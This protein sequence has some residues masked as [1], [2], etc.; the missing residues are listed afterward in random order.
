ML[1]MIFYT[2]PLYVF[3]AETEE[4]SERTEE[5]A[6]ADAE[7]ASQEDGGISLVRGVAEVT[8]R[9]EE[10]VKHFLLEDGSYRLIAYDSPVHYKDADGVWQDI[11]NTLSLG[12][13]EWSSADARIKFAKKITG[14]E[15]LFTLHDG[16]RKLAVSLEGALKKTEGVVYNGSEES[17]AET[18]LQKMMT[19]A[20]LYSRIVYADILQDVDLEYVLNGRNIKENLIVKQRGEGYSYTFTLALNGMQASL[21]EDGSVQL[22]D[23]DE[24]LYVMPTPYVYDADGEIALQEQAYFTLTDGGN[25]KYTLT[26]TVDDAWMNDEARAYPVTVDPAIYVQDG[27]GEIDTY[28]QSES[29]DT[30]NASSN[31]LE[32]GKIASTS[33]RYSYWRRSTLPE[34]PSNSYIVSARLDMYPEGWS[35][36]DQSIWQQIIT[37][38]RVTSY[39]SEGITWNTAPSYDSNEASYQII[40]EL[41]FGKY[42]SFDITSLVHSWY[43]D[44]DIENYGVR[45]G[46]LYSELACVRFSSTTS[47]H[48]PRFMID[49]RDMKG[50]EDYWSYQSQDVGYAGQGAVNLANGNLV[51]SIGTLTSTDALLPVTPTL[52]YNSMLGGVDYQYPYVDTSYVTSYS[53][54]GFK[55]NL[56]ETIIRKARYLQNGSTQYYYVWADGD[57]TEHS[58]LP[59]KDADGNLIANEYRDEDGLGLTLNT[60][61]MTITDKSHTVRKF[62]KITGKVVEGLIGRWYLSSITDQSGNKVSFTFDASYRPTAILLYP[63]G[64]T[65]GIEQLRIAYSGD[66]PYV[67]WNP[68]SGHAVVLR[69]SFVPQGEIVTTNCSYLREI[70]YAHVNT[71]MTATA[72]TWQSFWTNE[73]SVSGITVDARASY[74][75]NG[76]GRLTKAKD[77]KTGYEVV[78]TYDSTFHV[79]QITENGYV[80][81]SATATVG[82]TVKFTYGVGYT[83]VQSSGSDDVIDTSDDLITHTSF[84]YAGRPVSSFV[85]NRTRTTI[86]GASSGEYTDNEMAANS[87]KSVAQTSSLSVNHLYNGSFEEG[88]TEWSLNGSVSRVQANPHSGSS[89]LK[90]PISSGS[91]AYITQY[92][93]LDDGAYTLTFYIKGVAAKN[94]NVEVSISNYWNFPNAYEGSVYDLTYE[95]SE[96]YTKYSLQFNASCSYANGETREKLMIRIG[97]TGESGASGTIYIDDVT[98]TQGTGADSFSVVRYGSFTATRIDSSGNTV[99]VDSNAWTCN[100]VQGAIYDGSDANGGAALGISGEIAK[101][102]RYGQ[103]VSFV[104]HVTTSDGKNTYQISAMAK[105][106]K[107]TDY[108]GA[109]FGILVTVRYATKHANNTITYEEETPRLFSFSRHCTEWQHL[110]GVFPVDVPTSTNKTVEIRIECVYEGH[111]GDAYFDN[112]SLCLA[113]GENYVSYEYDDESGDVITKTTPADASQ[114]FYD[115][116]DHL[117]G[118][119]SYNTYTA[120]TYDAEH[121]LKEEYTYVYADHVTPPRG[122]FPEVGG[123]IPVSLGFKPQTRTLYQ[124]NTFGLVTAISVSPAVYTD[125]SG[126]AVHTTGTTSYTGYA[127]NTSSTSHIFGA[128]TSE[129]DSLGNTTQYI[130]DPSTGLLLATVAPDENAGYVYTYDA[131]GILTAVHPINYTASTDTYTKDTT[132]A[133]ASYTYDSQG[134]IGSIATPTTAYTFTYNAFGDV[135]GV[136]VGGNTLVTNSYKSKNG[137][138]TKITYA[139]GSYVQYSYNEKEQIYSIAYKSAGSSIKRVNYVYDANG[140]LIS[141]NDLVS[142]TWHRYE[143]DGKDRL[144]YVHTFREDGDALTEVYTYDAESRMT[145]N[146]M[147]LQANGIDID[148]SQS[149]TY[150]DYSNNV[151]YA[152]RF[153]TGNVA[154][155]AEL[156]RGVHYDAL[157]RVT[158]KTDA[159]ST[160]NSASSMPAVYDYTYADTSSRATGR[161]SLIESTIGTRGI[162]TYYTYDE[163]GNITCIRK[164]EAGYDQSIYYTYDKLGQLIREDNPIKNKTYVY[165]YDR[166]GNITSKKTYAYTLASSIT[167]SPTDTRTYT[168]GNSSFG[169]LLTKYNGMSLAYDANFNPTTYYNGTSY[170]MSWQYGRQLASVTKG[171]TTTSYTYNADGIRTSKTVGGVEHKYVLSG[172]QIVAEYYG[173]TT[174]IYLYDDSGAPIGL[175]T[176]QSSDVEGVYQYYY[177]EKNLQGDIL[178]IY[179][180]SGQKVVWYMYD[181]Y[182]NITTAIASGYGTLRD[183]NPFRYR[184]YYYDTETGFYYLNSRYYDPVTGRFINIDGSISG[185]GGNLLGNNLF[186]YCFNNPI[187]M[188][189]EQGEWP[190]WLTGALNV[191]GGALQVVAGATLGATLGWTGVG[192]VAAGFLAANGAA[193]VAQGACQVINDVTDTNTFREDNILRTSAVDLGQAIGGDIGASIAGGTYDIAVFAATAYTSLYGVSSFSHGKVVKNPGVPFKPGVRGFQSGVNPNTLKPTKDLAS[194]DPQRIINAVKYGGDQAISVSLSGQILDGHHRVADAIRN[195]RMIDIFV[196][197]FR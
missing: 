177:F 93:R 4:G 29:P 31:Y 192:A 189:D 15:A 89:S 118:V 149:Y 100:G 195:G 42:I 184:G 196:E 139:D 127:Y 113:T 120:Y 2:L 110:V 183:S 174:N 132:S 97:V 24:V 157:G 80:G 66:V 48:P 72:S 98:V 28:T 69:Y 129:T 135:T 165:T 68:T 131:S 90:F 111:V 171:G 5:S 65:T 41:S 143:Y 151:A 12:G 8:E 74:T 85:T 81:G 136:A 83:E 167:S 147:R 94:A 92:V 51:F 55:L 146:A 61:T 73:A 159:L 142:R 153:G 125:T 188:I 179:T 169:D 11:D 152:V 60:S 14:N 22:K 19:L 166:G 64:V 182:G 25:G 121:R 176:R 191:I 44:S 53:P 1:L 10:S 117:T 30:G 103:Y 144:L 164:L 181:A 187:N 108:E 172:S 109:N 122:S 175:A 116:D 9:R 49:Y 180:S 102:N 37:L 133:Y 23:G 63:S 32:V 194:L 112:I 107:Q 35:R 134:R 70:V 128:M 57:G 77:E 26:V 173:T 50:V 138:P 130:Y 161:V 76:G 59:A 79:M 141:V 7:V 54:C 36:Y 168:Y 185:V 124:Y 137:K 197:P 193:T 86:Y 119:L 95:T 67:I 190:K 126:T 105:G 178:G 71:G 150:N 96:E 33:T 87:L 163:N 114:Y 13:S 155:K 123:K 34:L 170:S 52:V 20:H 75:Y 88:T 101:V 160:V 154:P 21:T 140:R 17:I 91:S 27:T 47:N 104:P 43:Y 16:N 46:T 99:A 148:I 6:I 84:D 115:E 186:A 58:F 82:Q 162:D 62:S 38:Y 106:T 40:N 158:R 78:Y 56:M 3:A 39:W 156:S 145:Q 18:Q 45:F